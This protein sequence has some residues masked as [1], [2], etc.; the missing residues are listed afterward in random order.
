MFRRRARGGRDWKSGELRLDGRRCLSDTNFASDAGTS[1]LKLVEKEACE[2]CQAP[3]LRATASWLTET[4]FADR[5]PPN[6]AVGYFQPRCTN[7]PA[8]SH[9][10][11]AGAMGITMNSP[12]NRRRNMC[13]H[14]KAVLKCCSMN[15]SPVTRFSG[16]GELGYLG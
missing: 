2:T 4:P 13:G 3:D 1:H 9:H 7:S 6:L 14:P 15:H 5:D 12:T 16:P 8:R 11:R 10:R